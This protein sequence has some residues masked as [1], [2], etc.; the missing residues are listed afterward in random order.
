MQGLAS[1]EFQGEGIAVRNDIL[2]VPVGI[3]L[4]ALYCTP[5]FCVP[6]RAA[7]PSPAL[8]GPA[9]AALSDA[10]IIDVALKQAVREVGAQTVMPDGERMAVTGKTERETGV[11]SDIDPRN[12]RNAA[13]WLLWGSLAVMLGVTLFHVRDNLWSFSRA[14]HIRAKDEP[15][16]VP[17]ASAA[18]AARMERA[19]GEADALAGHG[20]YAEAIHVLLLRTL[21]EL[22]LRSGAGFAASLTSRELLRGLELDRQSTRPRRNQSLYLSGSGSHRALVSPDP[23][24]TA[25]ARRHR[26]HNPDA[27]RPADL[28]GTPPAS[29]DSHMAFPSE[30]TDNPAGINRRAAFGKPQLQSIFYRA[31]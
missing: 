27:R 24:G 3:F 10:R 9:S 25:H 12:I 15:S 21:E 2:A 13:R 26:R 8:S 29:R 14:R 17:G 22:R 5:W 6:S 4:A 30:K 28:R 16:A 23:A 1:V 19:G 7:V 11:P 20:N 18:S 31:A